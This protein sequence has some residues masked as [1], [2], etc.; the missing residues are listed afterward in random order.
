MQGFLA[1]QFAPLFSSA[2]YTNTW[3]SA[4]SQ[5]ITSRIAPEQS[6]TT[7]VSANSSA[8]QKLAQAYTMVSE[9][10]GAPLN[11]DANQAA[12]QTATG[13][14]SSAITDLVTLQAGVG[15]A[16]SDVSTANDTMSAQIDLLTTQAGTLSQLS[17]T[18]SYD[19]SNQVTTLQ[20]Q[21]QASYEVTAKLQQMS[22][23]SYLG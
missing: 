18:E 8:F 21:I 15:V 16:Q 19:I 6:V 9:F 17:D 4:S 1:T 22:L 12:M 10:G 3:S 11:A 20:T 13:L 7:S 5:A 23:A 2:N 14:V